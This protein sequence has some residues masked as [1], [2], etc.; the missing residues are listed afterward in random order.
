[1][2]DIS[3]IG[4]GVVGSAIARRLAKYDLDICL[5]EKGVDV[6][7]GASKANSGIVHGGYVAKAGTLKGELCIK[8][9][10]MY[11]QLEE[12]LN[13][14]FRRTG[15][16][17]V[18]FDKDDE[19]RL[20]E[21]YQNALRVGH[22]KEDID[23]IYQDK[24]KELEPE[25]N[26]DVEVAFYCKS[27]GVA[28]PYEMT[29]A[30]AENAIENGVELKLNSEVIAIDKE[31]EYFK[32]KTEQ[33]EIKSRYV[34]NAAGVYSDKISAML[35]VDDFKIYPRRGQYILLGKDQSDLVNSVIFQTPSQKTKGILVTTTYH[36]NLMIG[37]NAE[38][39]DKKEDV[40]TTIE[41]LE[42]IITTAK[43]SI[44]D[45][46]IKRS[47]TTFSGI[48]ASTKKGDFIIEASQVEGLVNVA[49]ID[50]PGLTSSPAIAERVENILAEIGLELE[51]DPEFNPY[52]DAIIKPKDESFAGEID[53]Q[54]PAKNI[55]CRCEKVT[56]AEIIDALNRGIEINSTDAIKRRTRAGMG[57]CQGGFCQ[58]RVKELLAENL[59]LKKEEITVRGEGAAKPPER[60][61]IQKIRKLGK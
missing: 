30:L 42:E 17:V 26:D 51:E 59:D 61:A 13:F 45:F 44:P 5:L 25:I 7:V 9:N 57:N 16:I 34:I 27:V 46:N 14:G 20:K 2:Y 37:P 58:S 53:H 49:G 18:G 8:G 55:I 6:S 47:L 31:E 40:S 43:K 35:G 39:I 48:R 12:E 21:I 54:N 23:L 15:A 3:I 4:A 10:Q 29:I 38:E 60:I 56:E 19:E 50:S 52:R 41:E 32:L 22:E 36:G 24:I 33:E 11:D 1:M 28:S